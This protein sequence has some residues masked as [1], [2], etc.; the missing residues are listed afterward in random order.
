MPEAIVATPAA[1]PARWPLWAMLAGAVLLSLLTGVGTGVAGGIFA[2]IAAVLAQ[3]AFALAVSQ[4]RGRQVA[5]PRSLLV[6]GG[7]LALLWGGAFVLVLAVV[8]W[9]LSALIEGGSLMAALGLSLMAGLLLLGLWRL[10]PLWHGLETEGGTLARHW[11]ELGELDAGA[12]RGLGVSVVVAAALGAIVLL[13]WPGLL[14]NAARWTLALSLALASPVLHW[15][16]QRVAPADAL[17]EVEAAIEAEADIATE[18]APSGVPLETELY[19]AARAGRVEH[20]LQLIDA[21][22]NLHASP[23]Y[24]ERD[25]RSLAVLAA[26]LPDLRLL[27]ALIANGADLNV[28]HAGMTPLLAATR[29]SWHG[30]PDAV[31]TLL[32]NGADPRAA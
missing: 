10:W 8:T 3:P 16:L 13:A 18:L 7:W 11:R 17:P 5:S 25:Q 27:R 32:A 23:P 15:L 6:E 2:A 19:A 30:R 26:V 28:A 20:A 29:D 12:W 9:P 4:F 14:G 1:Q 22:A 31:M 24:E 21:G